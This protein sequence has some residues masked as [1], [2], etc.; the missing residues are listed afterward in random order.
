MFKYSV[1]IFVFI[2]FLGV[3][4]IPY[5]SKAENQ[6]IVQD[7]EIVVNMIPN[8]PE[9]YQDVRIEISSYSTD[10]N[11]AIITWKGDGGVV[12]SGVGKTSYSFKTSGPN[13]KM[14]FEVVI[15]PVGSMSSLTKKISIFPS[16]VTLLWESLD[17]YTPPFYKGKTLNT[18]GSTIKAVAIPNTNTIKSGLG[19]M[20]YTWKNNDEVVQEASGYNKNYYTFKGDLF[21]GENE[22]SVNVSSV[23][24]NYNAE[25]QIQ[26][27]SYKGKVIFYKKSPTEGVLYNKA[28]LNDSFFSGEEMSIVAEPFFLSIR[29]R[30][31][32]F[33]YNWKINGE[34]IET[35]SKKK[36]ITL[37]PTSKGGYATVSVTFEDMQRLFQKITGSLK[38]NL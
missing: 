12:L 15:K 26:I 21:D 27:P 18:K 34:S 1:K 9:P 7:E 8:N 30:E 3:F 14:N 29:N 37:R 31:N 5:Y 16:E 32:S 4:C 24:G 17:G 10:L 6:I 19:N 13:T 2:L 11:K 38:L 23:E 33:Y 36:E 22:I 35:P 28:L 25:N 20:S